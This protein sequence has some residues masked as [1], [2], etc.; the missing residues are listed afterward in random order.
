M[1]MCDWPGDAPAEAA[2]EDDDG[3]GTT[4]TPSRAGVTVNE[5]DESRDTDDVLLRRFAEI[6]GSP[7]ATVEMLLILVGNSSDC[8][9]PPAVPLDDDVLLTAWTSSIVF[10]PDEPLPTDRLDSTRLPLDTDTKRLLV[11][12]VGNCLLTDEDDDDDA[13]TKVK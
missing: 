11:L 1:S 12:L 13:E 5:S 7:A 10:C 8:M 3:T 4:R 6:F 2:E 9:A